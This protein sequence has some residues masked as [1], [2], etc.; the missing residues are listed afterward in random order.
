MNIQEVLLVGVIIILYHVGTSSHRKLCSTETI[1]LAKLVPSYTPFPP[2][3]SPSSSP[4]MN[5]NVTVHPGTRIMLHNN[6]SKALVLHIEWYS[7]FQMVATE[8]MA[9][10]NILEIMAVLKIW[11]RHH[12]LTKITMMCQQHS[13]QW[14]PDRQTGS[15]APNQ[16]HLDYKAPVLTQSVPVTTR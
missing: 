9:M 16:Y 1:F 11:W 8:H 5:L 12:Q 14:T 4:W 2:S 10:Y 7:D 13:G 15:Q 6:S 3:S